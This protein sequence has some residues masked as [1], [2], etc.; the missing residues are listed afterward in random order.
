[1]LYVSR[2]LR[3]P[4]T[5]AIALSLHRWF[6]VPSCFVCSS[7]ILHISRQS[8]GSYVFLSLEL[9][10][11][12]VIISERTQR[13]DKWSIKYYFPAET[14]RWP[15][16]RC[17][18][19]SHRRTMSTISSSRC[20]RRRACAARTPTPHEHA[21]WANFIPFYLP[22]AYGRNHVLKC[23]NYTEYWDFSILHAPWGLPFRRSFWNETFSSQ[24]LK[25]SVSFNDV[26][27]Y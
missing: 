21:P 13:G 14:R 25:L 5:R 15:P 4:T 11:L 22:L 20:C 3:L 10:V 12:Y 18:D 17:D 26:L 8:R 6:F 1:M 2:I 23:S 9:V 27:E 19:P 7:V 16:H 24:L